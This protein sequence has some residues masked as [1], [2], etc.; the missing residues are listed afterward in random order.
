MHQDATWYGGRPQPKQLCDGSYQLR[1]LWEYS[2]KVRPLQELEGNSIKNQ[3]IV[4]LK[5]LLCIVCLML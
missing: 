3:N 2:G 5:M 1:Q 4:V